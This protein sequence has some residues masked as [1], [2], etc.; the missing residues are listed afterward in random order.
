M[1]PRFP[2]VN[3]LIV[4]FIHVVELV[5]EVHS[6]AAYYPFYCLLIYLSALLVDVNVHL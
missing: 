6:Y 4:K 5:I 1:R 3:I 2:S